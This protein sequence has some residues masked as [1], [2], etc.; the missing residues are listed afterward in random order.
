MA[1][2]S[3]TLEFH[4]SGSGTPLLLIHG[5][6]FHSQM[7]ARQLESLSTDARLIAPD[8]PGF[9]KTGKPAG[10]TT[11]DQ[12]AKE[13]LALLDTLGIDRAVVG[14]LSMG[15]YITLAFVRLYPDRLRGLILA[16]TKAGAD[17]AEGKGGRDKTIAGVKEKG[18]GVVVEGMHPKLLAPA[19]YAQQPSIATEL[20]EIMDQSSV[21]GVVA[22]LS[23]MR[24][25][26]D[27]APLL[28]T[29]KT[30][31]L[32]IHGK[33][34]AIIPPSEA[35]AMAK[36]IPNSELRLIANAGHLPN[37]EQQSEFDRAVREFL[38][39]V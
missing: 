30:P 19:N 26:P 32:V 9:G 37:M 38:H 25:R 1:Q 24:D 6:P 23:A 33:E 31:T 8:L 14:G 39:K 13:C 35:E 21:E 18:I 4:E 28:S 5:F 17:S 3:S 16:S 15:G 7:W 2:K 29:I 22:A 27:S 10:E 34:D 20:K 11:V 36:A 12:Y